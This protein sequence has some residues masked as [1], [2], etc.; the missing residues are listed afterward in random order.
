MR[1]RTWLLITLAS[2]LLVAMTSG[3]VAANDTG[4][5]VVTVEGLK[6]DE[7]DLRFVLFD[8]KNDFLKQ[9]VS[10]EIV[11]INDRQGTWTVEDLPHGAYAVLVHHDLNAN[12]KMERHW[13]GKP[14]EPTGTSNDP[15]ARM[16]P[17]LWKKAKF[18]FVAPT[19]TITITVN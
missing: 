14:K 15:P 2:A 16:G 4:T 10:A 13:Y 5:L 8:S 7:G 12:G 9:P 18:E 3:R 11:E 17:P 19:L 1:L 6:A